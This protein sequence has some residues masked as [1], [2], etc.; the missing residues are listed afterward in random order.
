MEAG[1]SVDEA[2]VFLPGLP[3]FLVITQPNFAPSS[4]CAW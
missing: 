1:R 2:A 4:T 3:L